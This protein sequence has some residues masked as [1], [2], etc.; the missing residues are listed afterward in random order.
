MKKITHIVFALA[1]AGVFAISM[2]ASNAILPAASPLAPVALGGEAEDAGPVALDASASIYPVVLLPGFPGEGVSMLKIADALTDA[3]FSVV[4]F[5]GVAYDQFGI[6]CRALSYNSDWNSWS[7]HSEG[8]NPDTDPSYFTQLSTHKFQDVVTGEIVVEGESIYDTAAQCNDKLLQRVV[9]EAGTPYL[10]GNVWHTPKINLITHSM[11][12]LVSRAMLARGFLTDKVDHL[13]N[14]QAP[15]WGVPV[16]NWAASMPGPIQ[17]IEIGIFNVWSAWAWDMQTNSEF[18]QWLN[19][20]EVNGQGFCKAEVTDTPQPA[21]WSCIAGSPDGLTGP[22]FAALPG[23][24]MNKP[25]DFADDGKDNVADTDDLT[26]FDLLVPQDG[27][28]LIGANNYKTTDN[29]GTALIGTDTIQTVLS[30][31]GS[32]YVYTGPNIPLVGNAFI[33]IQGFKPGANCEHDYLLWSSDGA[34]YYKVWIDADGDNYCDDWIYLGS[35]SPGVTVSP[36]EI[37]RDTANTMQTSVLSLTDR[38]TAFF[39]IKVEVWSEAPWWDPFTGDDKWAT[40]VVEGV[41]YSND[42]DSASVY[43]RQ[44]SDGNAIWIQANGFTR[45]VEKVAKLEVDLSQLRVDINCD[46]WPAQPGEI[47]AITWFGIPGYE[48]FYSFGYNGPDNYPLTRGDNGWGGSWGSGT[49][50]AVPTVDRNTML[51]VK[52]VLKSG[53]FHMRV[54]LNDDDCCD[55]DDILNNAFDITYSVSAYRDTGWWGWAGTDL[56]DWRIWLNFRVTSFY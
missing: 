48:K 44:N 15:H 1:L 22:L 39:N 12:G 9:F 8:R 7:Y 29:H 2:A 19:G 23:N 37:W 13:I 36:G 40:I 16:S 34:P 21:V 4:D 50:R 53:N 55:A 45:T 43:Y 42:I 20:P 46:P 47:S 52:F 38:N 3:G 11:G 27:A 54:L 35:I 56:G 33:R 28:W 31:L 14:I 30:I 32:L 5:T 17:D 26:G 10:V 25:A 24:D 51:A 41:G 49:T 6:T 18:L